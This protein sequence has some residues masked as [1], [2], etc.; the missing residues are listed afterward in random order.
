ML[1]I[2]IIASTAAIAKYDRHD[3]SIYSCNEINADRAWAL[4]Q[5][6]VAEY[7]RYDLEFKTYCKGR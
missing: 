6:L 7:R 5:G 1:A 4:R 2:L 3:G